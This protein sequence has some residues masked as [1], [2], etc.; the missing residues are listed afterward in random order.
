ME[1]SRINMLFSPIGLPFNDNFDRAK[2]SI[3][4]TH[5]VKHAVASIPLFATLSVLRLLFS[6][7]ASPKANPPSCPKLLYEMS[8]YVNE[9]FLARLSVIIQKN[10][11]DY[12]TSHKL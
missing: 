12:E 5:M 4:P 10:T 7:I 11:R 3:T 9:V 8:K 6:I 1:K 2:F